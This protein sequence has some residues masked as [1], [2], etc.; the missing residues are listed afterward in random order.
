VKAKR[1]AARELREHTDDELRALGRSLRE[2]LFKFRMQRYTNQLQDRMQIRRVRRDLARL[3][4]IRS[5]RTKGREKAGSGRALPE[6]E[7]AQ[8]S[9]THEHEHEHE[10]VGKDE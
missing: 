1:L 9:A 7:Q 2:D 8:G 5:L 3:E 6:R 4:T 10:H